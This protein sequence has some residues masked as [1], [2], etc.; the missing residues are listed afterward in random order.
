MTRR[1]LLT[2]SIAAMGAGLDDERFIMFTQP[3][4]EAPQGKY[5]W[6]NHSTLIGTLGV[7]PNARNAVL[8]RIFEIV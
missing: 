6:M 5:D 3:Q 1:D 7:R 4:F 8:I 2:S